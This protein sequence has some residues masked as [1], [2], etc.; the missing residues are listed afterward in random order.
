M[1]MQ[2]SPLMMFGLK[3]KLE[4]LKM[5]QKKLQEKLVDDFE[6][7][8]EEEGL[9]DEA[10][11]AAEELEDEAEGAAEEKHIARLEK[12][13]KFRPNAV[14]L[15]NFSPEGA[16]EELE[17]EAEGAAEEEHIERLEKPPKKK[18]RPNAVPLVN[19]SPDGAAKE[20]EDEVEGAAEERSEKPPNKLDGPAWQEGG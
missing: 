1:I 2:H 9:K 3:E 7:A 14:P 18:F 6:G 17:D 11:G 10:E 16:A 4:E 15:V 8:A 12:P 19:L 13:P 20:L 5:K